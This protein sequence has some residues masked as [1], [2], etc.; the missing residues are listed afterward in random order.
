[1]QL[2]EQTKHKHEC[3]NV[4]LETINLNAPTQNKKTSKPECFNVE[5]KKNMNV[6]ALCG[7]NERARGCTGGDTKHINLNT[8]TCN[9]KHKPERNTWTQKR[10]NINLLT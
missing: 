4:E 5:P 7:P 10:T 2:H 6:H 3:T 8:T 1:M 9:E